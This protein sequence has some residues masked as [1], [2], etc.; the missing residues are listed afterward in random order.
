[1][2]LNYISIGIIYNENDHDDDDGNLHII[3]EILVK[4]EGKVY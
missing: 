1:M 2:A 4:K 3:M